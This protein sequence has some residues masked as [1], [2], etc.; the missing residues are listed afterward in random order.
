M[1]RMRAV[2]YIRASTDKQEAS[3]AQ[4]IKAIG[5]YAEEK[6]IDVFKV[7]SDNTSGTSSERPGFK[8]LI[9]HIDR[10]TS[11]DPRY[12]MYGTEAVIIYD[13]SRW[14]RWLDHKDAIYWEQYL[15]HGLIDLIAVKGN[16]G[17]DIGGD[18]T[19]MIE[20]HGAS[21]YS[22]KLSELVRRGSAHNAE[23]G[24]WNGGRAP[25]GYAR[26]EYDPATGKDVGVLHAGEHKARKGNRVKL[27]PGNPEEIIMVQNL[28]TLQ[29]EGFTLQNSADIMNNS[30]EHG[31]AVHWTKQKV[32]EI[33]R[34]PVYTGD[35]TWADKGGKY[36]A[37]GETSGKKG[38]HEALIGREH[39]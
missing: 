32:G 9:Q 31:G 3:L 6:G 5:D 17:G 28:F 34:N 1:S 36:E 22:K 4:Q 11:N 12:F 33:L 13:R 20:S 15:R 23:R 25:Y 16:N 10:V 24:N 19:R 8:D 26:M 21:E 37:S 18:I 38:A 14:G 30:P 29:K 35:I 39:G 27:V 2:A 7:F